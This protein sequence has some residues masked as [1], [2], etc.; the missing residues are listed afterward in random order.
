[1]ADPRND[2]LERYV[3]SSQLIGGSGSRDIW[4]RSS[5]FS[6]LHAGLMPWLK[7]LASARE[8]GRS[9]VSSDG[10]NRRWFPGGWCMIHREPHRATPR[11]KMVCTLHTIMRQRGACRIGERA[12]ES[13]RA[14]AW[15]TVC[16]HP[17]R[18]CGIH[19]GYDKGTSCS[20]RWGRALLF[21]L[22]INMLR[23]GCRFSG[24]FS[25]RWI[26]YVELF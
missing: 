25:L 12:S 19:R 14:H 24:I 15:P 26:S 17:C 5:S 16:W 22:Q 21:E 11:H 4:P 3:S 8:N 13:A 23:Y 20:D 9:S 10:I 2:L 18:I 7:C 1:M 6:S